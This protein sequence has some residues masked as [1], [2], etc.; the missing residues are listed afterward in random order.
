M[1]SCCSMFI[2]C[3]EC[4]VTV[5]LQGGRGRGGDRGG[6]HG[7]YSLGFLSREALEI[8]SHSNV[9]GMAGLGRG[10]KRME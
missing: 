2:C 7:G 6:S 8:K 4:I 3:H 9:K 10:E 5:M 1:I